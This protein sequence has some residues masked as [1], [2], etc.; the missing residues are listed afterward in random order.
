MLRAG[1]VGAVND[2]TGQRID[3]LVVG[4]GKQRL[5]VVE[6]TDEDARDDEVATAIDGV[7]DSGEG[8]ATGCIGEDVTTNQFLLTLDMAGGH[9]GSSNARR[10]I[11]EK[12]HE[13]A[14]GVSRN[15]EAP[16]ANGAM[17]MAVRGAKD[18]VARPG[19]TWTVGME[20]LDLVSGSKATF[21]FPLNKNLC[22]ILGT[23]AWGQKRA[24]PECFHRR[25]L[26]T[27]GQNSD[28]MTTLRSAF[29]GCSST[30]ATSAQRCVR[31]N[32]IHTKV[33]AWQQR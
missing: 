13:A 24:C 5:G 10:V 19:A 14:M 30:S 33:C 12:V 26:C 15:L 23:E 2:R 4:G 31:G 21:R 9:Q 32:N 18:D 7:E 25:S 17:E 29:T 11:G 8:C 3:T 22:F 20:E 27:C 16:V 1:D 28:M 6:T